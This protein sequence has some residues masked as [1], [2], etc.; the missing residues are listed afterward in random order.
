MDIH[1]LLYCTCTVCFKNKVFDLEFM[2]QSFTDLKM[3]MG[4]HLAWNYFSLFIFITSVCSSSWLYWRVS[5]IVRT[6]FPVGRWLCRHT[7][8]Q[9]SLAWLGHW[10]LPR[11]EG[12]VHCGHC[13]TFL[14]LVGV[15][16]NQASLLQNQANHFHTCKLNRKVILVWYNQ[17]GLYDVSV[18]DLPWSACVSQ[19]RK[20]WHESVNQ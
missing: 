5:W 20:M 7:Q 17:V 12:V 18:A 13:Q 4:L 15:G 6:G 14:P 10:T 3:F 1:N 2:V 9:H 16:Q 8:R 19:S 11:E